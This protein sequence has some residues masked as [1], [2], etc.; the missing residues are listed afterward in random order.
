MTDP[1]IATDL[2]A[3][4][5]DEWRHF[6]DRAPGD[7]A[8]GPARRVE[9][10][11]RCAGCWGA[12][13]GK[14]DGDGRWVRIECRLC[15]RSVDQDDAAR[16]ADRML[17]EAEKNLPHVRVGLGAVYDEKAQFVLKLLPDMDRD[18]TWFDQRVA[19][20][21][22]EELKGNRLGRRDFPLGS[23]GYLYGQACAFLAGLGNL[24]REMSAISLEDFDF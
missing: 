8:V 10:T 1:T 20:K 15:G 4:D 11:G 5:F 14:K 24:P 7:S 19:T 2:E 16:E 18:T 13:Q 3:A 17:L 6:D 9:I 12:V 22:A 21:A 23:A